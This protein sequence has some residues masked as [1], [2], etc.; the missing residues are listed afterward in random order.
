[1]MHIKQQLAGLMVAMAC[2]LLGTV[3]AQTTAPKVES[4]NIMDVEK[5]SDAAAQR[6]REQSQPGNNAPFWRAVNSDQAHSV[7]FPNQEA[8]VLIQKSGQQWRLIRNG[9]LTVFG[10]WLVTIAA[11][12][13][14]FLYFLKGPIK[15]DQPPTGRKIERFTALERLV[16]WTMAYSFVALAIT[17]LFI[18]FGKHVIMPIIGHSAHGIILYIFKNVHNLTGPIFTLCVVVFFVMMVKDNLP[19]KGDLAWL[20]S[21]G[22]IFG[23]VDA[24]RFNAGEKLWFWLGMT[25]I[26][27]I[28]AGSGWVLDMIVPGLSYWRGTMQVANIIHV[29]SAILIIVFAMGHIYIGTIGTEGALDGMKTGYCDESWAR[30]HHGIWLDDIN[31]GKLPAS[32]EPENGPISNIAKKI[33]RTTT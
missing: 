27:L 14:L 7:N 16:H 28:V 4:A 5:G 6:E 26:G 21:G 25:I 8:G 3:H 24:A 12:G 10:G 15:L 22:G 9:V 11:F 17:G 31:S 23:H 20:K 13:I 2:L 33:V 32:R 18:I 19:Q 29:I 30:Q 1:M